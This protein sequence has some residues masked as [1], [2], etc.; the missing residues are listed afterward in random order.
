MLIEHQEA[1]SA[2]EASLK[3]AEEAGN[4]MVAEHQQEK[5]ACDVKLNEMEI[6]YEAALTEHHEAISARETSLKD[7]EAARRVANS[8]VERL[9]TAAH[10]YDANLESLREALHEAMEK[11]TVSQEMLQHAEHANRELGEQL[12]GCMLRPV[13]KSVGS[14]CFLFSVRFLF[15]VNSSPIPKSLKNVYL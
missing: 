3:E 7:E 15:S 2:F 10:E 11:N 13:I 1:I 8:E 9:Q 4:A 5:Y 12:V 14:R 6:K